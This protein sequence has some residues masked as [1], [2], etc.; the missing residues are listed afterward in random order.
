MVRNRTDAAGVTWLC[1][2]GLV[3]DP[4]AG[5]LSTT[6]IAAS[7]SRRVVRRAAA[8]NPPIDCF[9]VYPTVS[10][11]PTGNAN[12]AV[13]SAETAVAVAQAAQFSTVCRVYAPMYRQVTLRGLLGAATTKADPALAL[14]DVVAAWRDYLANDN[15]GRGVVLIG[16]SQGAFV[17]TSLIAQAIDPNVAVRARLVSAILLGGNVTVPD[18]RGVGGA[19]AH[20]P[21]C[22]AD[23]QVGCV[24]AYSSFAAGS[25]PPQNSLF[26]RTTAAGMQVLCTNPAA[27]G[28]GSGPL[29]AEMPLDTTGLTQLAG[30]KLAAFFP[31]VSTPWVEMTG[32][33]TAGCEHTGGASW[34]QVSASSPAARAVLSAVAHQL[35]GTWGTHLVDV[36]IALGNLVHDVA[37]QAAAWTASHR[38]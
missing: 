1:R 13:Q 15:N 9:Y 3:G 33:F 28:G 34:L 4:C 7:G 14:Q 20:V 17:L 11:E 25:P 35:P 32:G 38:H 12:L 19:F 31:G 27:L 37:S 5:D 8:A 21:A 2:P 6:V 10:T 23:R 18:G 26:G 36:N 30:S 22:S 24:I 16:H 29:A